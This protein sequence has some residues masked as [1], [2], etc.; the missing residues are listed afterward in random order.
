MELALGR[1]L[2]NTLVASRHEPEAEKDVELRWAQWLSFSQ[3]GDESC[4]TL[5][6][7]LNGSIYSQS[8]VRRS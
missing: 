8:E 6:D 3:R 2:D 1:L 4:V 5:S 7:G